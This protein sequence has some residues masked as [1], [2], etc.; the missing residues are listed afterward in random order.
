VLGVAFGGIMVPALFGTSG[1]PIN[2]QVIDSAWLDQAAPA[3][4]S[5]ATSAD[6]VSEL[7]TSAE[8]A[9]VLSQSEAAPPADY[10]EP[11]ATM[12]LREGDT[13]YDLADWFGISAESIAAANGLT[14]E[15][16]VLAG[17]TIIIPVPV[18]LFSIPPVPVLYVA[19]PA[20]ELTPDPVPVNTPTPA[21]H[22]VF[23]GGTSDVVAAIC[24]LPWPCERMVRIAQCE[25][26]LN[27]NS[28][29]SGG[30]YGLFQINYY[31][32]GWNNPLVNAQTAYYGKY[33]PAL[34]GGGDGTSPWPHC[35]YY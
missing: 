29:N 9:V 3:A 34:A 1:S 13:F 17:D 33:L 11:W 21:T 27:P 5:L 28:H 31:F 10:V 19:E 22:L 24:S 4:K 32:D 12:E 26:G 23:T 16:Y 8:G 35:R 20:P 25:S 6:A 15:D 18:T 30:Y 14:L 7:P 2:N